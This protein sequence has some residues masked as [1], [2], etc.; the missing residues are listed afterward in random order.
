[1]KLLIVEHAEK[2]AEYFVKKFEKLNVGISIWK[3]YLKEKFNFSFDGLLLTGGPINA[4]ELVNSAN[5]TKEIPIIKES[6]KKDIP[7]LGVCLGHQL[8]GQIL[9]GQLLLSQPWQRGWQKQTLTNEGQ[10]D[11]LFKNC[12]KTFNFFE[13]HQDKIT[14]LPPNS[15]LLATSSNCKIEAF[16]VIDKPVWGVQFHPEITAEKADEIFTEGRKILEKDG[17]DIETQIKLG[18]KTYNSELADN[19]FSNFLSEMKMGETKFL[20]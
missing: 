5:F 4:Q 20:P 17:F 9:G 7:I 19:I 18:Y 13:F 16:R 1:M 3:P 2:R 11:P 15:I 14:K 12:S 10:N 8:L 6:I